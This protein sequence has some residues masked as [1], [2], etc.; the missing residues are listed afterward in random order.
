[1]R[2][3]KHCSEQHEDVSHALP[4]GCHSWRTPD[5]VCILGGARKQVH[6]GDHP[7]VCRLSRQLCR[8]EIPEIS[9]GIHGPVVMR[10]M[11]VEVV[12]E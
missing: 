4:N 9:R 5:Q 1:M 2:A 8:G 7:L 6:L 10:W 12:T 11:F 3:L